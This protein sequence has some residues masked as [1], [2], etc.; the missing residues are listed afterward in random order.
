MVLTVA[1]LGI[2]RWVRGLMIATVVVFVVGSI[3]QARQSLAGESALWNQPV[4]AARWFSLGLALVLY[5]VGLMPAALVL[6]EACGIWGRH[7][8]VRWAVAA[9]LIG[10]LGKYVPG[11]AMVVWLRHDVLR[12]VDLTLGVCTAAIVTETLL[13]MACGSAIAAAVCAALPVPWWVRLGAVAG[14]VACLVPLMPPLL[15]RALT[16]VNRRRGGDAI[17]TR[18]PVGVILR[19]VVWSCT[20]WLLMGASF[21]C[22]LRF[23]P[24]PVDVGYPVA[25]AA[26][27]LSFVA[28]FASLIPGGA[29]VREAV[30]VAILGV[31]MTPA[32]AITAAVMMRVVSLAVECVIGGGIFACLRS[33]SSTRDPD[34]TTAA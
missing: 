23:L 28:G 26:L 8:P 19:C 12:R 9:Q 25:L 32:V 7:P 4:T 2:K 11:K 30:L 22:V 10:H 21:W 16:W 18:I 15:G 33:R 1:G 20:G 3:Y 24:G 27:C 29:G 14:A 31:S 13:M 34:R 6:R 5:A 17:D